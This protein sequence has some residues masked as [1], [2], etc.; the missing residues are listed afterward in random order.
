M[1]L[2][3]SIAPIAFG[4][5]FAAAAPIQVE[6]EQLT[7]SEAARYIRTL[8]D[9]TLQGDRQ[10]PSDG[11]ANHCPDIEAVGRFAADQLW[12]LLSNAER[13][14]FNQ[15]FCHLAGTAVSRLRDMFPG[16]QL[17]IV[18]SRPAPQDMVSVHGWV[19][20]RDGRQWPVDW[21]VAGPSDQPHLADLRI[22]DVSLGIFLRS[23]A[24]LEWPGNAPKSLTPGQILRPWGDALDRALPPHRGAAPR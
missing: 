7:D 6:A 9:A 5:L 2:I 3:H 21:L 15:A 20:T 12:Q 13:Q 24:I 11:L 1:R 8:F 16:L 23:L 14:N 22:L 4:M 10:G 18:E 17:A 19:M